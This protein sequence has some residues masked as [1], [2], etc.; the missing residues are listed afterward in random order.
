RYKAGG[1][2]AMDTA[3]D[4]GRST[5]AARSA[6]ASIPRFLTHYKA[7][8]IPGDEEL[9]IGRDDPRLKPRIGGGDRAL[10]AAERG[11]VGDIVDIESEPLEAVGD[12]HADLRRVL[13]DA[14]GEDDGARAAECGEVSADVLAHAVAEDLDGEAGAAVLVLVLLGEQLAHVVREATDAE[15]S[16]LLV[17]QARSEEH[18][19]ELQS[20]ENL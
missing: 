13:A 1:R 6:T 8:R 20:R 2:L 5:R 15:Q 17:E 16:A 7:E 3:R 19:S 18:T 4:S 12:A 11:L 14:A 9:L 10:C